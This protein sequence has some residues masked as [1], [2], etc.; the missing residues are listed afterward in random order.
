MDNKIA[1]IILHSDKLPTIEDK[2]ILW[3]K[4]IDRGET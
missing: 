1:N 2:E 4:I 3:I